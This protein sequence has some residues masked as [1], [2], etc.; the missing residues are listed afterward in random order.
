MPEIDQ[1]HREKAA[2]EQDRMAVVGPRALVPGDGKTVAEIT[3]AT[4]S[5]RRSGR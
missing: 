4:N 2:A 3:M 5:K 1:A